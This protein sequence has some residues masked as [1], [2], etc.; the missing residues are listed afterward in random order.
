MDQLLSFAARSGNVALIR[1]RISSGG[2]PTR[3]GALF[4]A[5]TQ[6]H[7]Q[8]VRLLLDLGADP[9]AKDSRGNGALEYALRNRNTAL[10]RLLVSHGASL[11]KH[12]RNHWRQQLQAA[13][14]EAAHDTQHLNPDTP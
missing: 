12:S 10:V 1:E 13:L 2:D 8:A 5:T 11:A 3:S 4:I 9:N 7:I 6:G 14:A